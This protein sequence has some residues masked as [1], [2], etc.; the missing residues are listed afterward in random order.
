MT[1]V[2]CKKCGNSIS[3][4]VANCPRCGVVLKSP[5]KKIVCWASIIIIVYA[6]IIINLPRT[7]ENPLKKSRAEI[8]ANAIKKRKINEELKYLKNI[9]EVSWYEVEND[10]VY[11]GFSPVPSNWLAIIKEAALRGNK[12][13]NF[14]FHAWAVDASKKGWRPGDSSYYGDTTAKYGSIMEVQLGGMKK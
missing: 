13:I 11:I 1:M 4:Q 2:K 9:K 8:E 7:K 10:N 6:C 14:R 5:L 3:S 12:A